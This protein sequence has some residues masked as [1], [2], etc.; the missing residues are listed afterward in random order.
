MTATLPPPEVVVPV[1]AWPHRV[2]ELRAADGTVLEHEPPL[3]SPITMAEYD[4]KLAS[5]RL[6]Q[7]VALSTVTEYPSA[8]AALA[9]G[10]EVPPLTLVDKIRT[11]PDVA[12]AGGANT[13]GTA[14]SQIEAMATQTPIEVIPHVLFAL[15]LTRGT[16]GDP[17]FELP[18]LVPPRAAWLVLPATSPISGIPSLSASM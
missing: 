2:A 7:V 12:C 3:G 5:V 15:R 18:P 17:R 6:A 9:S 13:S 4:A 11:D 10:L 16:E 8:V 14:T 1:T